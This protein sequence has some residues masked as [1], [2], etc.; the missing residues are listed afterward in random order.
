[1]L[2]LSLSYWLFYRLDQRPS[3]LRCICYSRIFAFKDEKRGKIE[4]CGNILFTH[5]KE[6][7]DPNKGLDGL[8]A[9]YMPPDIASHRASGAGELNLNTVSKM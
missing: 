5:F 1:M 9:S 7:G 4:F 8:E 2:L 3:C 6:I